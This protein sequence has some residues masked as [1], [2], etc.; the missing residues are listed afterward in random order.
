MI[1][2]KS[3]YWISIVGH[4]CDVKGC[5]SVLVLDGNMKNARTVCAFNNVGELRFEGIH[6]VVLLLVSTEAILG[7]W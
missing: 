7:N 2:F 4:R 1:Y 6:L 3:A 5:G